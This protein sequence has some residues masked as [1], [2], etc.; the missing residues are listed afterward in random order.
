MTDRHVLWYWCRPL[1]NLI[2]S[3][4]IYFSAS[5]TDI[6]TSQMVG[7]S[8][9]MAMLFVAKYT[10]LMFGAQN[11]SSSETHGPIT[12]LKLFTSRRKT[13]CQH[14]VLF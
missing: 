1:I 13:S 14:V 5:L 12:T 11:T 2:N 9:D 6:S 7:W 4:M 10:P 8:T 3:Y